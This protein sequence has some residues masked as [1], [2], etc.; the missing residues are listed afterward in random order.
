MY[1]DFYHEAVGGPS[2]ERHS[3]VQNNYVVVFTVDFPEPVI[4]PESER[5]LHQTYS[6]TQEEI[7]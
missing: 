6:E 3:C 7:C 5:S 4:A 2:I 1:L